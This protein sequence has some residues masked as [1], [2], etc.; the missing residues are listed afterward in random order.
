M[1]R[2]L[3]LGLAL[4]LPLVGVGCPGSVDEHLDVS[5]A[6]L[7]PVRGETR[8]ADQIAAPLA[9]VGDGEPMVVAA[10]AQARLFLDT[11]PRLLLDAGSQVQIA[12]D[13][14]MRLDAGRIFVDVREGEQLTLTTPKGELRLSTASV[15]VLANDS[16]VE[17]YLVRGD[18]AYTSGQARGE[19]GEG[20]R[21]KLGDG[22]PE[23]SPEGLFTDWTGGLSQAGPAGSGPEGV[24]TLVGRIPDAYGQARWPLSI[25]RLDVRVRII[26]DLAITEVDQEFFNPASETVEGL[27]AFRTPEGAVL[28]RFAVDRD[29]RLVDGYIREKAQARRAYE[30]QVYRGS[31]ED[32]ALLEWDAPGSYRARI[33]PI[34]PGETRRVVV[35]YAEWIQRPAPGASRLYRYPMGGDRP[36]HVQELSFS[37]DLSEA[38]VN[39]VRA[40]AA[41]RVDGSR[42]LLRQS[43]I[44]PRADLWLELTGDTAEGVPAYRA[45]HRPPRRDPNADPGIQ[46]NEN[47]YLY[48]PLVLPESVLNEGEG[49]AGQRGLDLVIVQDV[50]AG[51]ER[52][53]LELGRRVVESL[54]SHLGSGDRVAIVASDLTLRGGQGVDAELGDATPAR[55]ESLLDSLARQPA[56]GATDLGASLTQAAALLDPTRPGA[57]VYVGDGAPTVGEL[58]ADSL[59]EALARLPRPLRSYAVAIGDDANV[60]LLHAITRGGGFT[61]RVSDGEEAADVALS[62]LSHARRPLA[63]RVTVDLGTGLDQVF[64]RGPR[65]VVVGETLSVIGR[66]ADE[67]PEQVHVRGTIAGRDFELDLPLH[68]VSL[69]DEGDLRLRWASERLAQLLLGGAGREEVADLGSRYGIITPYTSFYV[70]SKTELQRMDPGLR[71]Q[72]MGGSFSLAPQRSNVVGALA[73]AP[74]WSVLSL[75]GCFAMGDAEPSQVSSPESEEVMGA[76]EQRAPGAPQAQAAGSATATPEEP[77]MAADED[78]PAPVAAAAPAPPPSAEPSADA[79]GQRGAPSGGDF[80]GLAARGPSDGLMD[81]QERAGEGLGLQGTGRG[82]GGTGDGTVGGTVGL[83]NLGTIGHG[84]GSGSGNGYG[85][86]AGGGLDEQAVVESPPSS[87]RMRRRSEPPRHPRREDNR[88]GIEGPRQ[89]NEESRHA[90]PDPRSAAQNGILGALGTL[91]YADT[92]TAFTTV[93]TVRVTSWSNVAHAVRRCSAGASLLLDGRIALWRE[94]LSRANGPSAWVEAYRTARNDCEL[95]RT[96]DRQAFLSLMLNQAGTI[97]GMIQLYHLLD[98]GADRSFLRRT[99]LRRVRTPEQL[100]AVRDAFGSNS[101]AVLIQQVL[102]GAGEGRGK[103]RALR[104]LSEMFPSDL[105]LLLQLLETL[106][107]QH[108]LPGARRLADRLREDP[109]IDAGIR[110]AIGEMFLRMGDEPEARRVFSEIVEFAPDDALSRRR[111]GDLYR[112]HGWFQDAYRQYETLAKIQPDDPSVLLLLAQAAAGAGRLDEALSLEQ[113]VAQTAEPGSAEGIARTALL[114]SSVHFALLR[115]AAK[116]A[117]DDDRLRALDSRMRRAGVLREAGDLRVSLVWSHPDAGLSLWASYPGLRLSRPEDIDPEMGIE[118]FD[119]TEQEDGHYGVEVRRPPGHHM[120]AID[121]KLV[122][123]WKEGT[124][125]E[126]IEIRPL[127]FEGQTAAYA[128]ALDREDVQEAP[129][130]HEA[131]TPISSTGVV[132]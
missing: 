109:M 49:E 81:D 36:P 100:R 67:V 19:V 28:S 120:T 94:R 90:M 124:P 9:R 27:Y 5:V 6:T 58:S 130:S 113:R 39:H 89:Q 20:Q 16:G 59:I 98:G 92:N 125:E 88:Y 71:Q 43:D 11:G 73:M 84:G 22:A 57:V 60:D 42:V 107:E 123:V 70:P 97:P 52:G 21:L 128:F 115:K 121:A 18:V 41:L 53:P 102:H 101:D 86:G 25:R 8:V 91:A 4:V 23:V 24:G 56:G 75:P 48:L 117:H 95:P 96:R 47:D 82:G 35:T 31:T 93:T 118:A 77:E 55:V 105:D 127:H 66:V 116:E 103:L 26:H 29:G 80:G 114:W 44:T 111:L 132:R 122:I 106:E 79:F 30:Q 34:A 108:D 40:G 72:L 51:T 15:S 83:G 32:P 87:S 7:R 33:Y 119:V 10:G 131:T 104:R 64:P 1:V 46:E 50:S 45:R 2:R 62:I 68:V 69:D 12:A 54:A 112:A 14:T 78:S 61:R 13:G 110:T 63:Q 38:G 99:I 17:V 3:V 85:R 74:G 126:R 76:R 37:A 129:L 65:D